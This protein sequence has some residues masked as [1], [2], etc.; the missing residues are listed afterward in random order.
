M[1]VYLSLLVG[2]GLGLFIIFSGCQEEKVIIANPETFDISNLYFPLVLNNRSSRPFLFTA[3]VTH[4]EGSA[5]IAEVSMRLKDSQGTTRLNFEMLDDGNALNQHSG[6]VIAFDQIYSRQ[7]AG[8]EIT[9]PSDT[10]WLEIVAVSRQNETKVSPLQP[11]EVLS[12]A[13]P[14][15][16]AFSFPD[17]IRAGM[18]PTTISVTVNDSDGINDVR[19][20]LLQG[21]TAG[22]ATPAFQDTLFNPGNNFSIFQ[23]IIDSSYA[24]RRKGNFEMKFLAEDRSG[25]R[26]LPLSQ[27]VYFEN[28]PPHL[29][30]SQVPDTLVLPPSGSNPIDTLISIRVK[31]RQSLKDIDA[32]YYFSLKPDGTLANNGNPFFMWDNGLPF[33][34]DP[35]QLQYAGDKIAGDGIFS[36]TVLLPPGV[37]TGKYRFSF[38]A[39][40]RVN[41]ESTV[42]VD[43]VWVRN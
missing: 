32:V 24:V 7:I 38:Y 13:P 40:D 41:Q 35:D 22:Y 19:W 25:E 6:D 42:W 36:F 20:V 31:D 33:L 30:D 37:L 8:S 16:L 4:P 11:L 18:P 5:G 17:S 15:I 43:S 29:W 2:M 27:N 1:K 23:Q 21:F 28:T 3:K 26:S 10:Y 9:V 34:G 39:L 14:E 12:N